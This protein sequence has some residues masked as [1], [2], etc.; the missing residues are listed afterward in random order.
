MDKFVICG[1]GHRPNK[2]GGYGNDVLNRLINLATS[3]LDRWKP[4]QVISGMALG[5]DQALAI[6]SIR[7][8][9]P[10]TAAVPFKG[11]E[12]R[13]SEKSQKLYRRI[14]E[15]ADEVVVVC[16]GGYSPDKMQRRNEWM[17]D[18]A[19]QILTMFDG[20][21]GGTKNCIDYAVKT[22][23]QVNNIFKWQ[24]LFG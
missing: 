4:T 16:E 14:L 9:I 3:A 21:N 17:V 15:R 1:T 22:G 8:E 12:S 7:L 13:W 11:Q 10:V 20:S 19:D 5:W 6:A 23:K 2:L 18:R 24:K